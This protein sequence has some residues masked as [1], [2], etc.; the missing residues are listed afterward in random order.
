M[1]L[2]QRPVVVV[3]LLAIIPLSKL[4]HF[5]GEQLALYC[6]KSI[7]DLIVITVNKFVQVSLIP[8]SIHRFSAPSKRRQRSCLWSDASKHTMSFVLMIGLRWLLKIE[9]CAIYD[10]RYVLLV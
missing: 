6:G 4:L 9:A 10:H 8:M 7:G 5:G 2:I 1:I 3:C